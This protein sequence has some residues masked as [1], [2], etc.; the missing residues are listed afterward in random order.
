MSLREHVAFEPLEPPEQLVHQPA[1]LCELAADRA[2]LGGDTFLDGLADLRR[3][4]RFELSRSRREVFEP[5][6]C[7]LQGGF[8]V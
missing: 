4:G 6:P 7:A 2:C 8:D 1:H 3:Q 5:P